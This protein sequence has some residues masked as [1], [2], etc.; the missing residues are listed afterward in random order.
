MVEVTRP[1]IARLENSSLEPGLYLY[2]RGSRSENYPIDTIVHTAGGEFCTLSSE[3]SFS[4]SN[5]SDIASAG[6]ILRVDAK[7]NVARIVLSRSNVHNTLL[8]TDEC[9]NRCLFCSQPPR[10]SGSYFSEVQAAL[11][12]F[13]GD[14]VIGL[15]GGEP[16]IFW[17][18][19]LLLLENKETWVGDRKFHLLSHG[20]NFSN[21]G[22]VDELVKADFDFNKVL[23]GVPVHGHRADIHD[24]LTDVEGSYGETMNGL[25]NLGYAGANLEVRIVVNSYNYQYLPDIVSRIIST[26]R[27]SNFFIAV[28]QLEPTGWARNRYSELYVSAETQSLYLQRAVSAAI[29]AGTPISLYNYP[30]CHLHESLSSFAVQSISD[31]KNHFPK[32]C[33]RC[34]LR[35]KCAGFFKSSAT[36]AEEKVR[37][38]L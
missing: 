22:S 16:T 3:E 32:E 4:S 24:H 26:L 20:R 9:N 31:W 2:G 29:L 12:N 25:I 23:F 7:S 33:N 35:G 34:T 8:T 6:D 10:E 18:E 15:T 17:E 5:L 38:L 14:G 13:S 21:T 27:Y 1:D 36:K 30:L 19:L 11:A 28:M 37:P